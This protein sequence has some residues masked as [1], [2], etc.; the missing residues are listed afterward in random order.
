MVESRQPWLSAALP[1]PLLPGPVPFWPFCCPL[2]LIWP[3]ALLLAGTIAI[4]ITV[5]A[6]PGS[7][8]PIPLSVAA[9]I[10]VAAAWHN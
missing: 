10:T 6:E 2:P 3:L 8:L 4:P 1:L 9:R 5:I 7:A